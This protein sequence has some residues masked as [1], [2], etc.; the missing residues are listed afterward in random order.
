MAF[1]VKK[2]K[3]EKIYP[4]IALIA[5][6]GGGKTYSALRL[7]TGMAEE[8]KNETGK[9]AKILMLNTEAARGRYYANEFDYDIVDLEAPF[10]PEL[11]VEAIEF[12]VSEKYDILIIDSTSPEWDGKGGCLELQQKAGGTYQAWSRIT[13]R[14]ER[15]INAMSTSPIVLIATM[16]GKDQYEVEKDDRG[17]T[18]VKK[19]G[20]GAKQRD[21]FE[22]EFTCTFMI[23]QKTSTA[24][25]QKD[26]THIFEKDPPQKLTEA[27]GRK[28]M[29]W[30]NTSG[31]EPAETAK[32]GQVVAETAAASLPDIKKE[33]VNLCKALGGT[34]NKEMMDE[35]KKYV[36]SGNPNGIKDEN[37][38]MAL[39]KTLKT[40]KPVAE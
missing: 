10:E 40:M 24:E 21:G 5:P 20:A 22:Y 37:D 23:D 36:P 28:I 12:A 3:R 2:A 11:F 31:D 30:A 25:V 35:I 4:K 7:A 16:R 38:A 29:Q 26:N 17:K 34:K 15:F 27:H 19:I 14:H 13:P 8:I 9:D 32:F 18:S 39:L 6:S 33:I 1:V